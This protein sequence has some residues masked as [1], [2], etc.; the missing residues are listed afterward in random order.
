MILIYHSRDSYTNVIFTVTMETTEFD[1]HLGRGSSLRWNETVCMYKTLYAVLGHTSKDAF[2]YF[3]SNLV[4]HFAKNS[5]AELQ[6]PI[7]EPQ[8]K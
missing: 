1:L 2:M 6:I 5:L 8:S 7:T 4:E 3:I